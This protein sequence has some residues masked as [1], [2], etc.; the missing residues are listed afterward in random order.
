MPFAPSANAGTPAAEMPPEAAGPSLWAV[1]ADVWAE[2]PC[3]SRAGETG[4]VAA[5]GVAGEESD[6]LAEDGS[7]LME[8]A[9]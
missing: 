6:A 9:D 5:A 3:G 7:G 2:G 1:D 4:E 8:T